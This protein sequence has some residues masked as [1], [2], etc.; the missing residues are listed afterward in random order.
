MQISQNKSTDEIENVDNSLLS[1][2]KVI[3][4]QNISNS[5]NN[6]LSSPLKTKKSSSNTLSSPFSQLDPLSPGSTL[7]FGLT[8]PDRGLL[9]GSI[10]FFFKLPGPKAFIKRKKVKTRSKKKLRKEK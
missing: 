10:F 8:S 5:N 6:Q 7:S 4:S 9:L 3:S 1:E 2:N